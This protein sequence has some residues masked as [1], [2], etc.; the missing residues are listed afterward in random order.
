MQWIAP[1]PFKLILEH[2]VRKISVKAA[3]CTI[4]Q[5]KYSMPMILLMAGWVIAAAKEEF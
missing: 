3:Y 2:I 4:N 5:H 1:T